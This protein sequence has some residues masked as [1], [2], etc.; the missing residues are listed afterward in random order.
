[1]LRRDDAMMMMLLACH[2]P[3]RKYY[4]SLRYH[5]SAVKHRYSDYAETYHI[6]NRHF[7]QATVF[8]LY[9]I[10]PRTRCH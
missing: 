5:A 3:G 7:R 9:D 8:A 1:M 4:Q 6:I 2:M 10:S